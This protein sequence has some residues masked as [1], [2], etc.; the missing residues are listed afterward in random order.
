MPTPVVSE[1]CLNGQ[2]CRFAA[3]ARADHSAVVKFAQHTTLTY[4]STLSGI[5]ELLSIRR[6]AEFDRLSG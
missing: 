1:D 3:V 6:G 4:L 2:C 5:T